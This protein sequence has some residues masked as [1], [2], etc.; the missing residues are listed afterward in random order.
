MDLQSPAPG[1]QLQT[2]VSL[3][4]AW[5]A[6]NFV[7][8]DKSRAEQGNKRRLEEMDRRS[9]KHIGRIN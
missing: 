6:D 7:M 8:T 2:M 9:S 4:A 3:S 5:A 1:Q